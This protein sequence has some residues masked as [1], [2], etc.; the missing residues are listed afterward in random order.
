MLDPKLLREN[1]EAVKEATRVKRVASP[2]RVDAWLA[3]DQRRRAAQTQADGLKSEQKKVGDQVGL[4]KRQLKGGS[5]PELEKLLAEANGFKAK[6]QELADE[7]AAA[8]A[9]ANGIMLQLPAIPDPSWPVGKDDRDNVL[10]RTW[11]DAAYPPV[12]LEG[13][14]K[15]HVNNLTNPWSKTKI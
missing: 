3:A 7:Q 1:P 4:L 2:E 5:S 13:G 8:E 14:K 11:A 10:D 9:E 12:K 6:A 15:D